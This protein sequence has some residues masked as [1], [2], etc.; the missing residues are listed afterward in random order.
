[1]TRRAHIFAII[2]LPLLL[3]LAT[4]ASAGQTFTSFR[5]IPYVAGGSDAQK[6]DLYVPNGASAPTPLIIW[7]HGGGWQSGDK[8]LGQ[9]SFQ[10][11]FARSGYAVA[12]INYRLSGEAIFPAQ[13]HDCK[14]A[15]R[16][17]RANATQYNI[18]PLKIAVWGSSAGGHLAALVGT[19]AS[20]TDLEGTVGGNIEYSSR[21]QAVV[22]WYGPTDFL[23]MDTQAIAQGCQSTNHNSANSAE[24]LLVG[25]Q[26]QTCPTAV[27][28]ANP[29]TYVSDDDPPFFIQHGTADCTVPLGQSAI[30]NS[31]L[32]VSGES[33]VYL[34]LAGAGHG[35]AQFLAPANIALVSEFISRNVRDLSPEPATIAGRV[36]TPDGRGVRN[37]RVFLNGPQ[38]AIAEAT[39][40]SFGSFTF[41]DLPPGPVYMLTV[42]SKRYRYA[43][44]A[45][46][47][48][49]L[50]DSTDFLG[51]D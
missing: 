25:C 17:L 29:M 34:P 32:S 21:V 18:D 9:N 45:I 44:K 15:I 30:F 13:I 43:P 14:A 47:A 33:P 36:L 35:G 19:S 6:L 50:D 1:M 49:G 12:S 5:D 28:R 23:Q 41:P 37:A 46:Q 20:V 48:I 38:G 27:A 11:D 4:V 26:I 42:L 31:L 51:L 39:S 10:L 3:A 40:S 7:I 16:W 2:S 22:D 8:M 24:S